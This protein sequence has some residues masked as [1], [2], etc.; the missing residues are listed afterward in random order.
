MNQEFRVVWPDGSIRWLASRSTPVRDEQGR[1]L[2]FIG[3]NWDVT[4]RRT[5]EAERHEREIA[6]RESLAKS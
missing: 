3:V 6:Q 4:D 2:R 5:A 1:T